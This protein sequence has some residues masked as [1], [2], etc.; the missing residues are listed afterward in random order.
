MKSLIL[1]VGIILLLCVGASAQPAT[2]GISG[3]GVKIGFGITNINT[4]YE[5]LDEFLD[6][7]VGFS[8]GGFLT[9]DFNRQF[10]IQPEILFV[11]KGAE[12]DLLFVSAEWAID[13]LEIP[14]LLKFDFVPDGPVHPNL[15]VGPALDILLSSEF[16][17]I[18][19]SYD[20]TDA[21][22][23]TDVGLVIGGGLDYRRVTFDLRYT[24]GLLNVVDA[25]KINELTEAEPGDFYYLENDPSIKN[26]EFSFMVG[27]N[28]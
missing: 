4:E 15:Y 5:E 22:K 21:M 18:D 11:T 28:F 24:I 12:K 17:V 26:L 16:R 19:L 13:Y 2:V 8:G 9:Y 23:S 6:S 7:R 20:V 14:V 1:L 25:D 10:A 3:K 27:I